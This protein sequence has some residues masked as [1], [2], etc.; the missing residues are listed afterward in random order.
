MTRW[1]PLRAP[2]DVLAGASLPPLHAWQRVRFWLD[3]DPPAWDWPLCDEDH[4]SRA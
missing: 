2:E 4:T 3:E 1:T